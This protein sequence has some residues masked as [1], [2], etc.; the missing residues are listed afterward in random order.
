M[1]QVTGRAIIQSSADGE[2]CIGGRS[3]FKAYLD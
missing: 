3:P 1:R 2:N